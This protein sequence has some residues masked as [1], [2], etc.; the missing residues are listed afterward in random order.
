MT[1][2]TEDIRRSMHKNLIFVR[3]S[4]NIMYALI[5]TKAELRAMMAPTIPPFIPAERVALKATVAA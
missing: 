3:L 4:P 1:K 2:T 5:I